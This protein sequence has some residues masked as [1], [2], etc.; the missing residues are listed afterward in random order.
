MRSIHASSRRSIPPPRIPTRNPIRAGGVAPLGQATAVERPTAPAGASGSPEA[1]GSCR[2]FLSPDHA[3]CPQLS[4]RG[5]E[6]VPSLASPACGVVDPPMRPEGLLASSVPGLGVGG[7]R[8]AMPPVGL[9]PPETCSQFEEAA[10]RERAKMMTCGT[11]ILHVHEAGCG[12][13]VVTREHC[14]CRW[15]RTCQWIWARENEGRIVE[16]VREFPEPRHVVLTAR[17]LAVGDL[18]RMRSSM[19]GAFGRLRR[20]RFWGRNVRGGIAFWGLTLSDDGGRTWH[21]HLHLIADAKGERGWLN[22]KRLEHEWARCCG[23]EGLYTE[24]ARVEA[25]YDVPGMVRE[26]LKGTEGDAQRL[27]DA[28]EGPGGDSLMGEVETAFQGRKWFFE[29]G[30]VRMPKRKKLK[31][32]CPECKSRVLRGAWSSQKYGPGRVPWTDVTVRQAQAKSVTWA[33]W[34][35]GFQVD[36]GPEPARYGLAK[37]IGGG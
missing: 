37:I 26:G 20:C 22:Q 32:L 11:P 13:T 5:S 28:F 33:D 2:V 23:R 36:G 12:A 4:A 14:K 8:G 19:Q 27:V 29:F 30:N 31:I 25:V 18:G 1:L 15:C 10:H 34:W 24:H 7:G 21:L 9:L 16:A 6:A 3:G 17:N 35:T